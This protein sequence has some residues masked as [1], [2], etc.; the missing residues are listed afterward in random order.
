MNYIKQLQA[1]NANLKQSLS[2][3]EAE[4]NNFLA[5]LHSDKFAG[6]DSQGN[7][8]DWISIS[9]V[10]HRIIELRNTASLK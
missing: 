8:K 2:D 1:D 9:D 6:I 5:H 3:I 7:R 10:I 4:L